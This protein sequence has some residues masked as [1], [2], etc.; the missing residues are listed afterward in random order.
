MTST[1][2]LAGL[3]ASVVIHRDPQGIPHIRAGSSSDAFFGQGWAHAEDRLFQMEYD[4]R[5]AYGRWAEWVGPAGLEA[6]RLNRRFRI[7]DSA[8]LDWERATP[9]AR[10][11]LTA[12]A[13][14]VNAFIAS[15]SRWGA[16]FEIAGAEPEPWREW[17]SMAVFKIRH[18]DMGPWT[19][20]L[21]RARLLRQLG[22]DRAAELTRA[23]QPHPLLIVPPGA[24]YRGMR[25]D[26]YAEMDR[27]ASAMFL[28]PGATQGSNNWALA[29][30]R[31]ASGKPLVAGDPHR[32]LDVPN[33]YYQNH[34][35]CPDW[36]A[37]GLS[38]PGVP[39]LPHF[40]HN[41][42]VAWCVTHAMADYQDLFIERFDGGDPPRYEFRGEWRETELRTETIAVRGADP[43]EIETAATHHGPVVIGE[44]RH[45][46]AIAC[47]YTALSG[48]IS[49]FDT[50]I[51]MLAARS[52][53][54]LGVAMRGWVEP[55]NNLVWADV[56]GHIGYRTRGQVPIRS[57]DN[58]WTPVPGWTGAHEWR[59]AIPFEEM[60]AM[61][62][63]DVGWV[64][65]ANS[66]I[67]GTD[68]PHY[69]GLDYVA[70]FRTRRVVA[71]LD[72]MEKAS[73]D[74]MAAIHAD[75]VCLPARDML[76]LVARLRVAELPG[77]HQR[78]PQWQSALSRL[79]SWDGVMDKDAVAPAIFT[80]LR[81]RL[82]EELM[83]P[84]LGPLTAEAFAKVPGGGVAH[85][86]RLKARL[87]E[88][89]AAD[90]R[91]LL[92]AGVADWRHALA[93][94]LTGA[95]GELRAA[96][97]DDMSAWRWERLHVTRP[98]HPLAA[99][100]PELGA[101]LDPPSVAVGGDG[102]TVNATGYVPGAGYHVSLTSVARYAFDLGD[103]EASAWVVPH[104]A[105]G[106]A[107]SPHWAD[108]LSAWAECRLL[109]MRYDWTRILSEA[110]STTTLAPA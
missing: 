6:D 23:A 51:P 1:I 45:G 73:V 39:G 86:T 3:T 34:L 82:M 84:I 42:R 107:D 15:T 14:G 47:A 59:G 7:G 78:D 19:A 4:R 96:L 74:D 40:G 89:I 79:L 24:E 35:A 22:P 11:M 58:A 9:E 94:A 101:T 50:F 46:H 64:A 98:R 76:E 77:P 26:G 70:D 5:R 109:P 29:G 21:W 87:A 2:R 81:Q 93:R 80:V 12:F 30:S 85:M 27:H 28:V 44:P 110:E 20:K 95:L 72:S 83:A 71:R 52:G 103:W 106:H 100:F 48:P 33:V 66:K 53:A 56:D 67:T 43:V 8:R 54:E 88:L 69:L 10:A 16:E 32:S 41:A 17:D 37:I 105:S 13:A 36:D 25:A 31:T 63:P 108:Q 55:A 62:D 99:G 92:P 68:Y 75:R 57:M 65:T 61:S 60:P 38:F 91:S 18:L 104:G 90:D 97:G 49:T 102:E